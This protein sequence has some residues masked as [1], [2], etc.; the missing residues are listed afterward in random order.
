ME[1]ESSGGS[2]SA[3]FSTLSSTAPAY[4]VYTGD[5]GY[6]FVG[7]QTRTWWG[8]DYGTDF[9]P[10]G[11]Y[12][13]GYYKGECLN[14]HA[15]IGDSCFTN[16]I[17]SHAVNCGQ[18]T[19]VT[20]T[21]G[22]TGSGCY[23]RNITNGD[24]RGYDDGGWDWQVGYIKDECGANEYVQGLSQGSNGYVHGLLCCPGNVT[25]SSCNVQVFFSSNS[26]AYGSGPDTDPGY[27]KG[28]CPNGQY[29]AGVSQDIPSGGVYS[30]LCCTP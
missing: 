23:P 11:D 4:T 18:Q 25:H 15:V 19:L 5:S 20:Y 2:W 9:S 27:N 26:D 14:G 10:V 6:Y 1:A 21:N 17:Q 24:N 7:D 13:P 3:S 30:L 16:A 22:Q 29:V 12:A 8:H 28:V